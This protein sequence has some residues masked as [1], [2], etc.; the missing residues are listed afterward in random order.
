MRLEILTE[1]YV[2]VIQ[3]L[4]QRAQ[5]SDT[6]VAIPAQVACQATF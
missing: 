4:C 3:L 1:V 6:E 2:T 5:I